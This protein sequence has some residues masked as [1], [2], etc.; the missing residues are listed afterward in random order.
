MWA[1]LFFLHSLGNP[2]QSC[3]DCARYAFS[4]IDDVKLPALTGRAC[5][6]RAGNLRMQV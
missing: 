2:A 6:A 5:G 4:E 1:I 3:V